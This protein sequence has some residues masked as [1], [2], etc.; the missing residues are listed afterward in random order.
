[1]TKT[2]YLLA[3]LAEECAEV[4]KAALKALRFGLD[5]F[6]PETPMITNTMALLDELTDLATTAQMLEIQ[7]H[8]RFHSEGL[9]RID[10][11]KRKRVEV[12]MEKLGME[13]ERP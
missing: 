13:K 4:S 12:Y 9:S 8:R 10:R 3:C 7:T 11:M 2:E 6:D 1:M 5:D